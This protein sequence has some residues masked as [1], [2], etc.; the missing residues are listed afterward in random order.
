MDKKFYEEI[1]KKCLDSGVQLHYLVRDIR[2]VVAH[3]AM[4]RSGG[5]LEKAAKSV[6][7]DKAT[8]SSYLGVGSRDWNEEYGDEI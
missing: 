8:L 5:H 1:A 4:I 3:E 7:V 2:F 6:G